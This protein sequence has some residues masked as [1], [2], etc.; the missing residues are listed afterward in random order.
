MVVEEHG[1]P[2]C[3]GKTISLAL[4]TEA[5]SQRKLELFELHA[6]SNFIP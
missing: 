2:A 4:R 3:A 5:I 1:T 6:L